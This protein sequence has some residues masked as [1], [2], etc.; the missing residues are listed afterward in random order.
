MTAGRE[1]VTPGF[2]TLEAACGWR[3]QPGRLRHEVQMQVRNLGDRRYREH[4]TEGL[5]GQEIPAPGRSAGVT[6]S[7]RF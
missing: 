7:T 2:A 3:F 1:N 4:L 5:S 6:W